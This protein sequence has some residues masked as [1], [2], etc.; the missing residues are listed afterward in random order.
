MG[1]S[2]LPS[3]SSPFTLCGARMD[4][5]AFVPTSTADRSERPGMASDQTLGDSS[6]PAAR[7]FN[8]FLTLADAMA[9]HIRQALV[10]TYG[11]IEGPHG[12]AALLDINPH[13]VRAR[14]RKLGLEWH[15]FRPGRTA[16]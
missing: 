3:I 1:G 16:S 12:A 14:M 7:R 5:S 2:G 9:E 8:G 15:Q 11:R 13:T 4:R 10:L 6:L